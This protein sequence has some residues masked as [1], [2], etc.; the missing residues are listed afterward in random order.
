MPKEYSVEELRNLQYKF[1]ELE[2]F[3]EEEYRC[4][5]PEYKKVAEKAYNSTSSVI[6]DIADTVALSEL[7]GYELDIGSQMI[8]YEDKLK[9]LHLIKTNWQVIL[10]EL[11]AIEVM[12]VL[13]LIPVKGLPT[14]PISNVPLEAVIKTEPRAPEITT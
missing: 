10:E 9:Y 7:T 1:E 6:A 5:D 14:K 11:G 2:A 4:L 8:F 12:V 13:P 3:F